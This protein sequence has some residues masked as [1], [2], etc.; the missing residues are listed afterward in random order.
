MAQGLRLAKSGEVGDRRAARDAEAD[1]NRAL[2][3]LGE[4]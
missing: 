4:A 2:A 1:R 3:G